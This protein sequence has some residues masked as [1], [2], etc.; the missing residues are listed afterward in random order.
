ML[1]DL[2]LDDGAVDRRCAD[3][4]VAVVGDE[5]D[6]FQFDGGADVAL[7][8]VDV[9][10]LVALNAIL[11]ATTSDYSVDLGTPVKSDTGLLP[12]PKH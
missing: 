1:D 2:G 7:E 4:N 10:Q 5:Q 8:Q 12:R 6:V 11:L 3:S 9:E